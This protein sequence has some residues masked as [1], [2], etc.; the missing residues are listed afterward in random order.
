M[1]NPR[2]SFCIVTV[3]LPR[4]VTSPNKPSLSHQATLSG[5]F[6][7]SSTSVVAPGS[8]TSAHLDINTAHEVTSVLCRSSLYTLTPPPPSSLA[9]SLVRANCSHTTSS[10]HLDVEGVSGGEG[11]GSILDEDDGDGGVD[12]CGGLRGPAILDQGD[13]VHELR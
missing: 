9:C 8:H 6:G 10:V 3:L 1:L 5:G 2:D 4:T 13:H 11:V 7:A 12:D